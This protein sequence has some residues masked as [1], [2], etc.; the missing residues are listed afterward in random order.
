M[1]VWDAFAAELEQLASRG[2]RRQRRTAAPP[3]GTRP[4]V[5]G[6]PV[7]AFCSNDYLGL[8]QHPDI[9]AAIRDAS[10][11]H[12]SGAGAAHLISGHSDLHQALE[13]QLAR[14]LGVPAALCF[15][16]GYMANLG[17]VTA[18]AGRGDTVFADRL[19]HASLNDA[20]LLSRAIVKRYAHNDMRALERALAATPDGRRLIISDSVFSMDGDLAPVREL[21]A[22]AERFDALLLL[23]DAHGF[24]VLGATGSG[25]AA[26]CGLASERLIVMGTLGKAAGVS[27]A[28][29]AGETVLIDW[30]INKARTY[31]Y[32]TAT[33][34]LLA[35]G[36][37]TSLHLIENSDERRAH[38]QQLIAHLHHCTRHLPWR[39]MRSPT[40]IQPLLVGASQAAVD[41]SQALLQ[42]GIWVP[43]IRPPTVPAGSA[44]LRV[45]LSAAHTL[46]DVEQ[47]AAALHAIAAANSAP[48]C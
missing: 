16:T 30:L 41:L 47:L 48:S 25:I 29:V 46:G 37:L 1:S 39:W 10:W 2:Q 20:M 8:A 35:A 34:P 4:R 24:G 40:P 38:L 27:G 12:G 11:S 19:N 32:T 28:F 14:F 26:H 36:L 9:G 44:R 21:L 42:R 45:S 15:S 33:P 22:L 3:L 13:E 17:V 23:D 43:A 7:L 18:L 5:D 31:I 6:R